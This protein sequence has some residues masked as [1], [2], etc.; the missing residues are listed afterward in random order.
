MFADDTNIST[1]GKSADEVEYKLNI[2]LEKIHK[3]L[4][5]NKLTLNK[6]KTEYMLIAI[7]SRQRLSN[8]DKNPTKNRGSQY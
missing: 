2:D 6:E 8:I 3:W 1:N 7:G 4:L 5:A